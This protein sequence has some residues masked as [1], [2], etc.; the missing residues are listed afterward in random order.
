MTLPPILFEDFQPGTLM[1]E[2]VEV[3]D[4][5]Q[6]QRWMAIFGSAS[7]G[8]PHDAAQAASMAIVGMMRAYLDV[9]APRPPGNVHTKQK[10]TMH[11]LPQLGEAMRIRVTC[12][13]KEM[14]RARKYV[15]LQ[16]Q[17]TGKDQ[18]PLFEGLLT[19]IWAA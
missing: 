3:Y 12:A 7:A 9:V 11:A 16:V 4:D 1:G 8:E 2:R 10:L 13:G 5:K 15:E 6:A 18:R 17:G 19:L 14:R